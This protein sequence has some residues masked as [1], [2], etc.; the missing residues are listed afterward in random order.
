MK[1]LTITACTLLTGLLIPVIVIA[2]ER[3]QSCPAQKGGT[4]LVK[5]EAGDVV[6]K[7]WDKDEVF[8]RA[9]S[10]N[11]AILRKINVSQAGGKVVVELEPDNDGVEDV[12]LEI[13]VPSVFNTD[14]RTG[15]GE[16]TLKAPLSGNLKGYTGAGSITLGNIGGTIR[17][18]TA[19]GEIEAGDI[20]GDLSLN[21]AGGDIRVGNIRGTGDLATA[22]GAVMVDA[23]SGRLS[24]ST[25]GGDIK[26]GTV[27]V[28]GDQTASRGF[29]DL[30]LATAGGDI[31]VGSA[32]GNI[33]ISTAGGSIM[34]TAARGKVRAN[35]SAGDIACEK[36]LGS[37]NATTAA[38]NVA[39]TLDP[40]TGGSSTLTTSAGNITLRIS[41]RARATIH[42]RTSGPVLDDDEDSDFIR[43]DFPVDSKGK[44]SAGEADITLNGGGHTITLETTMGLIEIRKGR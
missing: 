34:L 20:A 21:T 35:S 27:T 6:V 13:S 32:Q 26:I 38:G 23:A 36:V 19:G 12:R 17:M 39:L 28:P 9:I 15:A 14:L 31:T 1:T 4:L 43:S 3:T 44:V 10:L 37:V 29:V 30:S 2:G 18:Q 5:V 7:G 33:D 41:E 22:G 42:A 40:A 24:V 25:A 11:D 16:L 8:I